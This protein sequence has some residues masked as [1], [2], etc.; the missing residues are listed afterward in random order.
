MGFPAWNFYTQVSPGKQGLKVELSSL[1]LLYK[2][3]KLC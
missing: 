2:E 1:V 3:M